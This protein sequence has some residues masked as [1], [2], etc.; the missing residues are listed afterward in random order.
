MKIVTYEDPYQCRMIWDALWP[1]Q[2]MF[3]LWQV[4]S[5]FHEA[6]DRP[7]R[8]HVAEKRGKALGLLALC[9]NEEQNSYVQFPGETWHGKTWIE[10]NRIIAQDSEMLEALLDDASG[11]IHLR[12]LSPTPLLD[13]SGLMQEDETG[14]LFYP[15]LFDDNFENYWMSFSGK[16]RKKIRAEMNK[17][18]ALNVTYRINQKKDLDLLYGMNLESF[19]EN[20]YFNDIRFLRSF[21]FLGNFLE[22]MGMLRVTTVLVGGRVAAVDV[23]AIW[24]NTYTLLAGGTDPEFPGIAKLINLHHL[25]WSC[26]RRF[27][28][29]D[30]LCGNFNWKQRFH[31][32]PRPLYEIRLEKPA[33]IYERAEHDRYALYA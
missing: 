5:C 7:L 31:L 30:F 4:R 12:Y 10:Q 18:E 32:S 21:E 28:V 13:Y 24:K 11:S 23:G 22:A 29:V 6:F 15:G 27:D 9:W 2:G 20:S 25:K 1:S 14:F 16:S 17:L 33:V 26:S 8:F 3:D 19:K